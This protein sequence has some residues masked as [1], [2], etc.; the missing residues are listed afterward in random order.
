MASVSPSKDGR[1][2]SGRDCR[3]VTACGD[4]GRSGRPGA[5]CVCAELCGPGT[6]AIHTIQLS[7]VIQRSRAIP[8]AK[9]Y[10]SAPRRPGG[11]RVGLAGGPPTSLLSDL[12]SIKRTRGDGLG[13]VFVLSLFFFYTCSHFRQNTYLLHASASTSRID[14]SA[15]SAALRACSAARACCSR[16]AVSS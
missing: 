10:L 13:R 3:R 12:L 16:A 9:V 4:L 1:R 8:R 14:T 6:C 15:A 5:F 11:G 7:S 2:K